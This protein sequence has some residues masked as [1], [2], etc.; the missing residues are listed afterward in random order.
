MDTPSFL[1]Y[2]K[3]AAVIERVFLEQKWQAPQF[4]DHYKLVIEVLVPI[5]TLIDRSGA[6]RRCVSFSWSS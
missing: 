6:R 2:R 4:H 3:N 5:R 1:F